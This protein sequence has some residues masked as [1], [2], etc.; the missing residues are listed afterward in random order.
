MR[1]TLLKVKKTSWGLSS[2]NVQSSFGKALLRCLNI[3]HLRLEVGSGGLGVLI[4]Q[5]RME[6]VRLVYSKL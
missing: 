5:F 2:P 1:P 6:R 4:D 3:G